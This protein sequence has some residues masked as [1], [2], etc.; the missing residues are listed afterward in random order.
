MNGITIEPESQDD[1]ESIRRVVTAAFDGRTEEAD[2][3]DALRGSGD[4]ILSLVARRGDEILGHVAF[5]RVVVDQPSGPAGAVGLA[6]VCVLPQLQGRGCGAKLI[7]RGLEELATSGET[8]VLVVGSPAYYRRF[9]FS[10]EA[11]GRY[12]SDYAGPHFMARFLNDP[13]TAPSGPVSYPE[14][15]E[16][17]N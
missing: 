9:G 2:L 16:L 8:V 11:A 17:V 7:E 15:F 5:S 10:P 13:E 6:P 1:I 12:E 14:A 3:V 4:L